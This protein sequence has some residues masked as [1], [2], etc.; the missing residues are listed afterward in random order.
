MEAAIAS[1]L[2]GRKNPMTEAQI[3]RWFYETPHSTISD[4]LNELTARGTI[5]AGETSL[6]RRRRVLEYTIPDGP[7]RATED[8]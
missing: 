8:K 3:Q 1:L 6:S 5:E 7:Y 2:R 4:A